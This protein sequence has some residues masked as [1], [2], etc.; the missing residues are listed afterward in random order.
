MYRIFVVNTTNARAEGPF[1]EG[2]I[3]IVS[4]DVATFP[5]AKA[6]ADGVRAAGDANDYVPYLDF[7]EAH[8]Y[9]KRVAD[10]WGSA[11]MVNVADD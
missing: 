11:V 4:H 7:E 5:E 1:T 9:A 10:L 3:S 6:F 8:G 2:V